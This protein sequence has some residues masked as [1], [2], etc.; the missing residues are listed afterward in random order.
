MTR[1]SSRR[2]VF[3]GLLIALTVIIATVGLLRWREVQTARGYVSVAL[4]LMDEARPFD[5]RLKKSIGIPVALQ[6]RDQ[7]VVH[8]LLLALNC[9]GG[10]Y[11]GANYVLGR[12][13]LSRDCFTSLHYFEEHCRTHE[14]DQETLSLIE[15]IRESGC[16]VAI[17]HGKE[18]VSGGP[19]Q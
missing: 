3:V 15:R 9:D 10:K 7:A 14:C 5:A 16:K 18:K 13:F 2:L 12:Y 11:S 8:Y 6:T 17:A 1:R 4:G 19:R